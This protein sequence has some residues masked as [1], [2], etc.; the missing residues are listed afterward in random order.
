M[1]QGIAGMVAAGYT[2]EAAYAE[3]AK[4]LY[5]QA[6]QA[7]QSQTQTAQ[8]Y[9]QAASQDLQS[10]FQTFGSISAGLTQQS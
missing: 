7:Y 9:I 3:A 6:I 2:V 4:M 1:A 8:E 5:Q 10:F